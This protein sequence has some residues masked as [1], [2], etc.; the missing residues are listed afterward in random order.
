MLDCDVPCRDCAPQ[1]CGSS[2]PVHPSP[3]RTDL[4]IKLELPEHIIAAP[5]LIDRGTCQEDAPWNVPR[6]APGD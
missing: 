2:P 3:D 6:D 1:R 5:R 4:D